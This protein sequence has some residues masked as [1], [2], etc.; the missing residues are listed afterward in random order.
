MATGQ[1]VEFD[2]SE[3]DKYQKNMLEMAQQIQNGK[4]TKQMLRNTGNKLKRRVVSRAKAR[5]VYDEKNNWTVN[6]KTY[7]PTGNLFKGL[8]RG[9]VYFYKPTEAFAVRVYGG[10]P[11]FHANLLNTGH[12]IVLPNGT[13]M[14]QRFKGYNYFDEAVAKYEPEF[15]KDVDK[16][17]DKMINENLL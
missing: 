2:I 9:R 13:R 11:A 6:G 16:F 15:Y 14:P 12:E 4:Y 7:K 1:M 17:I 5:V 3:L 8:K 10:K